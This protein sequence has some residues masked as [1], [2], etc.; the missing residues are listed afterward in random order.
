V[1]QLLPFGEEQPLD[2]RGEPRYSYEPDQDSVLSTIVPMMVHNLI[3][4][5]ILESYA[6]EHSARMFAMKSA[7]DNASELQKDLKLYYNRARQSAVTQEI[8][9]I[10]GGAAA[11]AQ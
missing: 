7:T 10:V 8:S 11:L 9:E 3:Y 5:A 2:S 4:G 1:L 6:S